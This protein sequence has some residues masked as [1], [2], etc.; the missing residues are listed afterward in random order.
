MPDDDNDAAGLSDDGTM[1]DDYEL[2]DAGDG[3]RLERFGTFVVDRPAPGAFATRRSPD[4]WAK[5]ATTYQGIADAMA[6]QWGPLA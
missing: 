3:A 5:R 4:R 2:I 1:D 6:D